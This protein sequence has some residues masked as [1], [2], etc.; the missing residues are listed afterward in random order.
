[1]IVIS[2][3]I[4]MV[5]PEIV[6]TRGATMAVNTVAAIIGATV[7]V[8]AVMDAAIVGVT[9]TARTGTTT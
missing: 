8:A 5:S 6:I 3:V 7:A 9:L 1:M 4:G 2:T